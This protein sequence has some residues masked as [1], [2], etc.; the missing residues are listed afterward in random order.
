MEIARP[1]I[2]T[3]RQTNEWVRKYYTDPEFRD[4]AKEAA[5]SDKK[6]KQRMR[7]RDKRVDEGWTGPP[8]PQSIHEFNAKVAARHKER[9]QTDE[10]FREKMKASV[11]A[12]AQTNRESINE[13]ARIRYATNDAVRER[14]RVLRAIRYAKHK[15]EKE[16][17]AEAAGKLEP[18]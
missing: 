1:T 10:V 16:A 9:Y 2:R 13:A 7:L 6:S 17:L 18:T 14:V 12:Y 11:H 8:P 15:A 4:T 3:M 5:A